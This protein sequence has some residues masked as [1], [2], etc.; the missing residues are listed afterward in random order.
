MKPLLMAMTGDRSGRRGCLHL[1]HL[2]H[3]C[4]YPWRCV[5]EVTA[6]M[7]VFDDEM[8]IA[9]VFVKRALFLLEALRCRYSTAM[10]S[11]LTSSLNT[12]ICAIK[13]QLHQ[14]YPQSNSE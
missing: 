7:S 8:K 4:R 13:G 10:I 5:N 3:R 12:C 2:H 14:R 9:V 6:M 1:R 11:V